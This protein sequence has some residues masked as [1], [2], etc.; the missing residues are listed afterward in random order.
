MF[1][2]C[3]GPEAVLKERLIRREAISSVSDARLRHFEQIKAR[4]EPLNEVRDEM[5]IGVD[6]EM[7]L[8]QSMEHILSRDY[9]LECLQTAKALER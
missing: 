2:E 6:T 7:P 1:V 5:H 4:F 3:I 8:E 9:V